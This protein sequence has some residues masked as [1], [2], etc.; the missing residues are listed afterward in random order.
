[1]TGIVK[2]TINAAVMGVV[3]FA[4]TQQKQKVL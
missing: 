3:M 1:M 2:G 4:S